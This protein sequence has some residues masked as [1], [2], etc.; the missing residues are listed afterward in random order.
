MGKRPGCPIWIL[1]EV[2]EHDYKYS[3]I[4]NIIDYDCNLYIKEERNWTKQKRC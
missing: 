1:E 3:V 4:K 2:Q